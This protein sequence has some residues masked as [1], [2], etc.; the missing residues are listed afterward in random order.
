MEILEP[1]ILCVTVPNRAFANA[2]EACFS[3]AQLRTI[4]AQCE[5][6]YQLLNRLCVD[7]PEAIGRKARINTWYKP[8]DHS[9]LQAQP[10]PPEQLRALGFDGY[11]IDFVDCPEGLKWFL[12]ADARLHRTAIA[13]NP[14][15]VNPNQAM[16]MAA[17]AG[18]ASYV[19]GRVMNQV[20]RSRYGKRLPQNSTREISDARNFVVATV[21]Q[22]VKRDYQRQ[23]A[24]AEDKLLV[25]QEEEKQLSEEDKRIQAAHREFKEKQG[26]VEAR[27]R[28][29]L[30]TQKKLGSL[31]LRIESDRKK[32]AAEEA[33]EP[34]EVER[35]KL[36]QKLLHLANKRLENVKEYAVCYLQ[37][38]RTT[39]WPVANPLS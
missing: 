27:K 15:A 23:L 35:T 33:R 2:V 14:K 36:R 10:L 37:P 38:L 11:A 28:A 24:E 3:G 29:V 30:E 22:S 18:G 21:D 7:T 8:V 25:I 34:V 6:D 20:T 17:T 16:E 5:E 4:V 9:R 26:K 13:I 19:I 1:A 39:N 31:R 32:L 12:C